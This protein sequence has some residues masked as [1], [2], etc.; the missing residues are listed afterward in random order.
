MLHCHARDGG[1]PADH[2]YRRAMGTRHHGPLPD[3]SKTT[4]VSGSWYRLLHQMGGSRSPGHYHGEEH[5]KLC[6]KEYHLQV[7][8][9]KSTRLG[10]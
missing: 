3:G 4:K 2:V 8:D 6:M 10:Q 5:S 9:A 1:S 7:R